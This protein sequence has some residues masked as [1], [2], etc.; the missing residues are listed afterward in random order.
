MSRRVPIRAES[1]S[2]VREI[3]GQCRRLARKSRVAE[4][5]FFLRLARAALEI[6]R[7]GVSN[8]EANR[9]LSNTRGTWA[10]LSLAIE[11]ELVVA[12]QTLPAFIARRGSLA[13]AGAR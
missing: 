3:L 9:R 13:G 7:A 6:A 8:A 5:H 12:E 10:E 2:L 1:L 11:T 4:A